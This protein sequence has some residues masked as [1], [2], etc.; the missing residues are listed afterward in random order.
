MPLVVPAD[1]LRISPLVGAAD[2]VKIQEKI[3]AY[4]HVRKEAAAEDSGFTEHLDQTERAAAAIQ[5]ILTGYTNVP[6]P[7]GLTFPALLQ[8][9]AAR[10]TPTEVAATSLAALLQ[11][12]E[13]INRAGQDHA[14][15]ACGIGLRRRFRRQQTQPFLA[16]VLFVLSGNII[17][18]LAIP[19][20]KSRREAGDLLQ[21][22][23]RIQQNGKSAHG[24]SPF[25]KNIPVRRDGDIR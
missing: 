22:R 7:A 10:V 9:L 18:A 4:A 11:R 2:V 12:R 24:I 6:V 14:V 20:G 16:S 1:V 5:A 3:T 23:A 15:I 13:R 19:D 8:T 17:D 25:G 21:R